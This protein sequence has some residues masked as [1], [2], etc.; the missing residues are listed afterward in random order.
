[1]RHWPFLTINGAATTTNARPDAG[2][3]ANTTARTAGT[4][5]TT[6]FIIGTGI[7]VLIDVPVAV[8]P[9]IPSGE[10]G[11][12]VPADEAVPAGDGGGL[13]LT[14]VPVAERSGN[15]LKSWSSE[16]RKWERSY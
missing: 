14:E 12:H 15:G 7:Q 6:T 8:L 4:A 16:E 13:G 10:V 9:E 11:C 3:G 5:S 2:T 1:M